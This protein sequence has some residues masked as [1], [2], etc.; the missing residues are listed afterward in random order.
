MKRRKHADFCFRLHTLSFL[1]V[2]TEG[3]LSVVHKGW[4]LKKLYKNNELMV[5]HEL[6][7]LHE[8][9]RHINLCCFPESTQARSQPDTGATNSPDGTGSGRQVG[10]GS[11]AVGPK[12]PWEVTQMSLPTVSDATWW[13]LC[14]GLPN[15]LTIWEVFIHEHGYAWTSNIQDWA[16][17]PTTKV[18]VLYLK[19]TVYIYIYI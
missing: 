9:Y 13:F 1:N 8:L 6:N 15:S 2:R 17:A 11:E 16:G 3:F 14:S 10:W 7:W 18:K 5:T 12:R 19:T 4:Y